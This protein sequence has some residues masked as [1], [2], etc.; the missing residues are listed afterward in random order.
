MKRTRR[1]TLFHVVCVICIVLFAVLSLFS[2]KREEHDSSYVNGKVSTTHKKK[3]GVNRHDVIH[4]DVTEMGSEENRN[5]CGTLTNFW[6]ANLTINEQSATLYVT[7]PKQNTASRK[8]ID[9][10]SLHSMSMSEVLKLLKRLDSKVVFVDFGSGLGEYTFAAAMNNMT[11]ISIE[12]D[13]LL[14]PFLCTSVSHFDKKDNIVLMGSN[15]F[16]RSNPNA[17]IKLAN[18]LS[19]LMSIPGVG[20][21]LWFN[22]VV[23]RLNVKDSLYQVLSTS[24]E[25]FETATVLGI[26][27][28]WV[29]EDD[30]NAFR[31]LRSRR[32]VPFGLDR[33]DLSYIRLDGNNLPQWPLDVV[34][35]RTEKLRI[36]GLD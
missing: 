29:T 17:K 27:T 35:I 1:T 19:N 8:L 36:V 30:F 23:L 11:V 25:F 13:R 12:L 3:L 14:M 24:R 10:P 22:S 31:F 6:R 28:K 4:T 20:S 26:V 34:W 18:S 15:A 5:T 32:Y 2:V 7:D 9:Q 33:L 16:T 21:E